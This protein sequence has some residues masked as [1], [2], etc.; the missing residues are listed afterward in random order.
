MLGTH[1][2]SFCCRD[3][4]F[5]TLSRKPACLHVSGKFLLTTNRV[6]QL[7]HVLAIQNGQVLCLHESC[8]LL[9]E[10]DNKRTINYKTECQVVIVLRRKISHSHSD[11]SHPSMTALC[12][13]S[14]HLA[15]A[16]SSRKA[17]TECSAPSDKMLRRWGWSEALKP[18]EEATV[19]PK[20]V[21]GQRPPSPAQPVTMLSIYVLLYCFGSGLGVGAYEENPTPTPLRSCPVQSLTETRHCPVPPPAT[22]CAGLRSAG[23]RVPR[24]PRGAPSVHAQAAS[25]LT[26]P[27]V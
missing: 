17:K 9:P 24:G 4:N 10:T 3:K 1:R 12:T 25:P 11:H 22:R 23:R 5:A 15:R 13:G 27:C 8:I 14:Q 26:P 2:P 18:R 19:T 21:S 6:P 7:F 16:S 20:P